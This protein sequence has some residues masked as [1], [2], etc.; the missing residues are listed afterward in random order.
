VTGQQFLVVVVVVLLSGLV[1]NLAAHA[2][3][4]AVP[5]GFEVH[6]EAVGPFTY[7]EKSNALG[8]QGWEPFSVVSNAHGSLERASGTDLFTMCFRRG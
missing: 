7:K 6:C 3:G 5:R 2:K 4:G 1:G 8:R